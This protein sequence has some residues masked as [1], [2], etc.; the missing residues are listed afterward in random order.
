MYVSNCVVMAAAVYR[1]SASSPPNETTITE[2]SS[3]VKDSLSRLPPALL[4]RHL[5]DKFVQ[6][7][8][9]TKTSA[10]DDLN[11]SYTPG[12]DQQSMHHS[13]LYAATE[14]HLTVF[15]MNQSE[16]T[17]NPIVKQPSQALQIISE[18]RKEAP[19]PDSSRQI[20]EAATHC[21]R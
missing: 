10:S 13:R 16:S 1:T 4:K 20:P 6:A 11:L 12:A 9:A 5:T 15:I 17:A 14:R 19:P 21:S 3:G 2:I 7:M 18:D 8:K